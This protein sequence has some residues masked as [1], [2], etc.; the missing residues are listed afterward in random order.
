RV[1]FW[2]YGAGAS[3][4]ATLRVFSALGIS[5]GGA[6]CI[7]WAGDSSDRILTFAALTFVIS[8]VMVVVMFIDTQLEG[9]RTQRDEQ[10]RQRA[11]H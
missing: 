4:V 2:R 3:G 11:P 9:H 10:R 8:A 7:V 6:R 5:W 1:W